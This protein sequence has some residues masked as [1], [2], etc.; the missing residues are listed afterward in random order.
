MKTDRGG[1]DEGEKHLAAGA[2]SVL[3]WRKSRH[4]LH[5]SVVIER[6]SRV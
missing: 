2:V 1:E 4:E 6:I 5:L 3:V